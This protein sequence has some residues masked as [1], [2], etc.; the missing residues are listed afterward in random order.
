MKQTLIIL[1]L[2][3]PLLAACAAPT[4]PQP[5]V[6]INA[7]ISAMS[8][9]MVAGT[10]TAQPSATPQPPS[11]T[12]TAPPITDTP[13]PTATPVPTETATSVAFVGCFAP[14]GVGSVSV[15]IFRMENNTKET[16]QVYLNGVSL[17]G[18]HTVSCSYTVTTSFNTEIIFG[19]YEYSVQIGTK[20][21]ID[22]KFIIVNTDKTTMRI[23][24]K[25]V[26]VVGP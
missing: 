23:Y 19:N 10:L 1:L 20:R 5:T 13:T 22:G 21:T 17:S 9:T 24:D 2:I 18:N 8:E 11:A 6:D 7:T 15:G 26:V 25:K 16:L 3:T 12:P 14:A 4:T